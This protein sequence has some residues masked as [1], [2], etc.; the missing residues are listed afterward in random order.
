MMSETPSSWLML[1]YGIMRR[2]ANTMVFF[3]Y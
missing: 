3:L 1:S 2:Y